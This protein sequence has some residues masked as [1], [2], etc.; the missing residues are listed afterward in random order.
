MTRRRNTAAAVV[1]A[2][3]IL[4]GSGASAQGL[5]ALEGEWMGSINVGAIVSD[6]L[7]MDIHPHG[8]HLDGH[9]HMP[10]PDALAPLYPDLEEL[11][12][13]VTGGHGTPPV[14]VLEIDG[15]DGCEVEV[16]AET[17][18][19][20]R[21]GGHAHLHGCPITG[22]GDLMVMRAGAV[23]A[24]PLVGVLVLAAILARRGWRGLQDR[25]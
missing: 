8:D 23:P 20:D 17:I 2:A 24:L 10:V 6:A 11:G 16:E 18:E 12:G 21:W 9:W 5:E 3:V 22:E 1:F 13:D 19:S 7:E 25:R 14:V 4:V 15:I